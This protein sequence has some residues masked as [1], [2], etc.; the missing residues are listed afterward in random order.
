MK[1]VSFGFINKKKF[2]KEVVDIYLKNDAGM[3]RDEKDFQY[4]AGNANALDALCNRLGLDLTKIIKEEAR[5][6]AKDGFNAH[7]TP[8]GMRLDAEIFD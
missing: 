8:V 6:E 3:A 7:K 1:N 4:R 5:A 2:I